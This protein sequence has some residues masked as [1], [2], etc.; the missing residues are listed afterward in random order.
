MSIQDK[1]QS[2]GFR[3]RMHPWD[4]YEKVMI[5]GFDVPD[6]SSPDNP[7]Q[8][9]KGFS[10]CP[11]KPD[12]I[13]FT[14]EDRAHETLLWSRTKFLFISKLQL[15]FC[16]WMHQ[17]A[18]RIR[19]YSWPSRFWWSKVCDYKLDVDNLTRLYQ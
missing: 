8:P 3:L 4:E 18:W 10:A 1:V 2:L 6:R 11:N 7:Q 12:W 9:P 16:Q 5:I 13:A 19:G 15:N 14:V 17:R